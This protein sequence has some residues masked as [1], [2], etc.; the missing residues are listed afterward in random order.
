[1]AQ[2]LVTKLKAAGFD[3]IITTT[4]GT[5]VSTSSEI[6]VGDVVQFAGG[7][8]YSSTNAT[9]AAST[10]LKAGPAKVTQISKNGKHPYH[11]VHTTSASA[12]YGW[13]DASDISK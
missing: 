13:V 4:G 2:A 10:T 9:K 1:N 12:V 7:S 11:I 3:A 5:T 8:H 6:A